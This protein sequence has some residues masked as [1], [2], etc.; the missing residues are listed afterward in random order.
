MQELAVRLTA[1]PYDYGKLGKVD[2]AI[3]SL[4]G[5]DMEEKQ[6]LKTFI[7]L[8]GQKERKRPRDR[9]LRD[10]ATRSIVTDIRKTTA[11]IGYSWQRSQ[12]AQYIAPTWV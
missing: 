6:V 5:I 7:R 1:A 12:V 9:L 10:P 11:F 2:N 8:Y 4:D 3:D